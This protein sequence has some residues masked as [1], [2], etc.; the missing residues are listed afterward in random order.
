MGTETDG[1]IISPSE[2]SNL[3]GIKPTMGLTSRY[4]VIPITHR[5]DTIGPL[6]KTMSDCAFVLSVLAGKDVCN[7]NYTSAQPFDTP[8]DYMKSL[9]LSGLAGKRLGVPWNLLDKDWDE[10]MVSSK[11]LEFIVGAFKQSIKVIEE[12]GAVVVAANYSFLGAT[13]K[14][15]QAWASSNGS[16]TFQADMLKSINDY[17]DDLEVRAP[18]IHTIE[19][20]VN[21]TKHDPR[22]RYPE[23]DIG[24]WDDM[25]KN[26]YSARSETTWRAYQNGIK[27]AGEGAIL[28]ALRDF[29]LDA[30]ILP[31]FAAYDLPAKIGSP[32]VTVPMGV[33]DDSVD[34]M[35][36]PM[37]VRR[38]NAVSSIIKTHHDCY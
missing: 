7:D 23:V 21:C 17:L 27:L 4:G 33:F 15:F 37:H 16:I 6:C 12:A 25:I 29:E 5:Q 14:D 11:Q 32:V 28:S 2:H 1:S 31:S 18:G 8:P 36:D 10:F 24:I 9:N 13:Q 35:W 26:N 34:E 19:D 30:L 22:E 3:V 20:L 38:F